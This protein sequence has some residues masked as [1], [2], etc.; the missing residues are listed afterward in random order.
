MSDIVARAHLRATQTQI[1]FLTNEA[2]QKRSDFSSFLI[3]VLD[4][5]RK[6]KATNQRNEGTTATSNVPPP[7]DVTGIMDRLQHRVPLRNEHD[8]MDSD[9]GVTVPYVS[10]RLHLQ[11]EEDDDE[12]ELGLDTA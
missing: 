12:D 2:A 11:E 7:I 10:R 4:D 6:E 3:T 5:E 1:M 8:D 9:D